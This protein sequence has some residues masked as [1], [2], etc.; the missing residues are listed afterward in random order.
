MSMLD[1]MIAVIWKPS[2]RYE[3]KIEGVGL[4]LYCAVVKLAV[5]VNGHSFATIDHHTKRPVG[6]K[7]EKGQPV[8]IDG[9]EVEG[10]ILHITG[11][12]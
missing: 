5:P 10:P 3:G 2:Y 8:R 11:L 12:V 7:L 1:S 6:F 4:E 9:L